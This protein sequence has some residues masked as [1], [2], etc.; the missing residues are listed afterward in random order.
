MTDL[1]TK[2]IINT[3]DKQ[4]VSNKDPGLAQINYAKSTH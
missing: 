2:T 1:V 3:V 4:A